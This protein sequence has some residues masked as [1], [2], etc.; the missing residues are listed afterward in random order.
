M[1]T[2]ST[3]GGDP[4]IGGTRIGVFELVVEGDH[5]PADVA[6]QLDVSLNAVYPSLAYYREHSEEM[7]RI[8]R[9]AATREP[10]DPS[11]DALSPP[12]PAE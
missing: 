7:R 5:S 2:L 1:Q 11:H 8:R 3:L 12:K 6:D 10:N 4:R 9:S